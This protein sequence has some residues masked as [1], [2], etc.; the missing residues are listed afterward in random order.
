[1]ERDSR[2]KITEM[3]EDKVTETTAR[4]L[5]KVSSITEIID[6]KTTTEMIEEN[7]ELMNLTNV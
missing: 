6:E 4:S 5:I 2:S 1:M 7:P 3:I